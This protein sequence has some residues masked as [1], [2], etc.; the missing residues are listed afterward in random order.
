VLDNVHWGVRLVLGLHVRW[1]AA[2][3]AEVLIFGAVPAE[4]AQVVA[5]NLK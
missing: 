4:P 1:N 3:V 5:T 2:V